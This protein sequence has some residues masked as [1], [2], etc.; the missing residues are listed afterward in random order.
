MLH[1]RWI[2]LLGLLGALLAGCNTMEGLGRD[3]QSGGEA[4]EDGADDVQDRM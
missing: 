4:I 1:L 3:V 2:A